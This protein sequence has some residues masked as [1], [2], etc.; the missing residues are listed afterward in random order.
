MFA[1]SHRVIYFA[2]SASPKL[3]RTRGD[4]IKDRIRLGDVLPSQDVIHDGHVHEPAGDAGKMAVE[5][6]QLSMRF[7]VRVNLVEQFV[8]ILGAQGLR[9]INSVC[10]A[11]A[12]YGYHEKVAGCGLHK[13]GCLFGSW[14]VWFVATK[15][16]A[17]TVPFGIEPEERKGSGAEYTR[18]AAP[19]TLTLSDSKNKKSC[20]NFKSHPNARARKRR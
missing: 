4:G 11:V 6:W 17:N 12:R 20:H 14:L 10:L 19:N 3:Q 7:Y 16:P 5:A 15:A 1:F 2:R 18:G 9:S 8:H 13:V